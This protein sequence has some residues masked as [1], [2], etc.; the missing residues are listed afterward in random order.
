MYL[1]LKLPK[2]IFIYIDGSIKTNSMIQSDHNYVSFSNVL[3]NVL[4]QIVLF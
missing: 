2:H 4:L 1:Q 3:Q